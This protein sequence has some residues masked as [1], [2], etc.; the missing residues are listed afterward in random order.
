M[1]QKM[2]YL[3]TNKF[4]AISIFLVYNFFLYFNAEDLNSAYSMEAI[5]AGNRIISVKT[6]FSFVFFFL[7]CYF[8]VRADNLF[9][10]I[11]KNKLKKYRRLKTLL[12]F[13]I[14]ALLF[15]PFIYFCFPLFAALLPVCLATD[16]ML[17]YYIFI[18]IYYK[19]PEFSQ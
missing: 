15:F 5:L 16:Y 11:D 7:M 18:C 14:S 10:S 12:F 17:M 19:A 9:L 13:L 6:V 3:I 2:N 8:S 1:R 4:F